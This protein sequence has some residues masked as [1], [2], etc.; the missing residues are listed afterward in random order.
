MFF[1]PSKSVPLERNRTISISLTKIPW[2]SVRWGFDSQRI[3]PH[4]F[5]IIFMSVFDRF[6]WKMRYFPLV[7]MGY[8][9]LERFSLWRWLTVSF[10]M[11]ISGNFWQRRFL[12][13]ESA[14]TGRFHLRK[15]YLMLLLHFSSHKWHFNRMLFLKANCIYC[16]T[17]TRAKEI[18]SRGTH[19]KQVETA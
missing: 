12:L 5:I 2:R 16:K 15:T 9:R 13:R 14:K 8:F 18:M 17:T 19:K 6:L 4:S 10:E 3:R 11:A 1:F 7:A